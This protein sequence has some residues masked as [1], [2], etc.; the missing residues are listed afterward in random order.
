MV[1]YTKRKFGKSTSKRAARPKK[2]IM[3]KNN[4][5]KLI[6]SVSLK[7]SET[8]NTHIITENIQLYH[9]VQ[10]FILGT[11]NTTASVNDQSTGTSNTAARL[12]DE[13]IAKGLNV[14]MWFATKGDRPNVMFKVVVFRYPEGQTPTDIF[15]TQGST[16]LMLRDLNIEKYKILA[17]KVFNIQLGYSRNAV[18]GMEGHKYLKLWIPLGQKKQRY[19][20]TSAEP[21]FSN[22]GICT[23]C[24][25]S[26]GTLTTDNIASYSYNYKFYFKDP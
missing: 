15:Y 9:N 4:L 17:V 25:D 10:N 6:K 1:K 7:Q 5:V 20:D 22:I 24:Y 19:L 26:F 13:V 2:S 23:M 18:N 3:K 12:G 14:K 21:K 11:L 16:N 8:K